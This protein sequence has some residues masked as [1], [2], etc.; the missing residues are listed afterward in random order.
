MSDQNIRLTFRD[1][2]W[3][4]VMTGIVLLGVFVWAVAPAVFRLTDMPPGDNDTIE[5]YEFDLSNLKLSRELVVPAMRHR[6]MSPVVTTPNILSPE[7]IKRRNN[8]KR[9][10]LVVSK[11]LVVGVEINSESRA[12]PLHF[13][14]VHEIINDT[15]GGTPIAII[16]HWPSG[17]VAVYERM[18][19]NNIESFANSGLAGNGGMIFYPLRETVG[20]EQ[21]FS[22]MLGTS[23]SGTSV[24]LTPITHDVVGWKRWVSEHPNTTS[25][26]PDPQLKKRYRKAS[27]ELYFR[28]EK[29]YF[30]TEPKTSD[31]L[32][33]KTPVIAVSVDGI[34]KVYSLSAL[35]KE[36]GDGGQVTKECGGEELVFTVDATPLSV[37]VRT[38]DGKPVHATYALWFAWHANHPNSVIEQ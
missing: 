12:Y 5:S 3:V 37:T 6:A 19:N 21:L 24:T 32:N 10:P 36:A 30:P 14:H 2:G 11:D 23:V 8:S 20:G 33:P 29:I 4:L 27:P 13:L 26:G 25:L 28:T 7:D 38:V 22:P 15:L 34:E 18:L 17:H 1:G 16:W 31:N 9:D 35:L